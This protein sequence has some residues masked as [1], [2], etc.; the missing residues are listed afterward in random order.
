AMRSLKENGIVPE[1]DVLFLGEADEEIG[2]E[3]GSRWLLEHRREWFDG[4]AQVLNEGGTI[5]VVLRDPRFWGIETLQAGYGS[6]ELEASSAAPLQALMDEWKRLDSPVG[7]IHPHVRTGFDMLANHLTSPLTE[8]LRNLDRVRRNP[9]E[10]A[11][12]PDRYASFLEPR[13]FWYPIAGDPPD[14]PKTYA[15]LGVLSIPP[16]LPPERWLDP[17]V[18]DAA[19]RGA[20]LTRSFSG[21]ATD[22]SPY[23]T[24]FTDLLKRT[25]EAHF[26]GVPFGPVPTYGGVTTSVV[27]R[28]HGFPTYGYSSIPMNI[29]DAVRRHQSNERLYLRDYLKGID[30]YRSVLEEFALR[31]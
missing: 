2:Q 31:R 10:L 11:I 15:V 29:T 23:P 1:S 20:R 26:P 30:L 21:G 25:T 18:R 19:R 27:F 22:A 6:V 8:P 16:G 9:S 12:F 4:V 24:P 17:I 14:A 13:I 7:P 5:E 28:R 3:F